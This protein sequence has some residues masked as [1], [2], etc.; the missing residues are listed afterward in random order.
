MYD[1]KCLKLINQVFNI[2]DISGIP[3]MLEYMPMIKLLQQKTNDLESF[4]IPVQLIIFLFVQ[5]FAHKVLSISHF[6][7]CIHG[8]TR[9]KFS[10]LS[11]LS[12]MFKCLRFE[13]DF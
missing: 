12:K 4:F 3:I 9:K 2:A 10:F 11:S 7:F 1:S 8:K 6:V 13:I 5:S